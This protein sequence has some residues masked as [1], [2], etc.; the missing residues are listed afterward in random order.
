[1]ATELITL[2]ADT[3]DDPRFAVCYARGSVFRQEGK[4]HRVEKG[5][6]G[7]V[8]RAL[9]MA[10]AFGVRCAQC[11][12]YNMLLTFRATGAAHGPG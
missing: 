4:F 3:V 5:K 7:L 12:G 11:P 9:C 2:T 10:A 1:M 8:S 6:R